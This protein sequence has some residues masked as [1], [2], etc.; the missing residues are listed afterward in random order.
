MKD[1]NLATYKATGIV[2][3]YARLN[4]LQPAE[5]SILE[6]FQARLGEMKMLDIGIG[7]GRTTRYFAPLVKEYVGI[8]YS[9]EMIA[10]CRQ[11]FENAAANVSL[12]VSDARDLNLFESNYFDFI[13][14]SFNGIDYVCHSDRL[15]ILREV[16][17]VGK[18]G[19]YFSFSSHNLRAISKEFHLTRK[20]SLNLFKTYVDLIMFAIV[21]IFNPHI[22]ADKIRNAAYLIIRDES[23]NFR[24]QTYYIRPQAQI[25]QLKH[26]FKNIRVYSWQSGQQINMD[27]TAIGLDMWLYY[28]CTIL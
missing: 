21:K 15:K 16:A 28:L 23:H 2:N 3:Y 25:E 19:G 6:H 27:D 20:L 1:S 9:A 14:F 4:Q 26:Y 10:A 5:R 12:Q 7:G 24:L 18:S 8:D 13:L 17:R 11:K 22:T